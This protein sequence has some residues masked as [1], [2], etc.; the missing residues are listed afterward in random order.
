MRGMLQFIDHG[1]CIVL[2]GNIAVAA[3]INEQ[4]IIPQS[5]LASSCTGLHIRGGRQTRPVKCGF[6]PQLIKSLDGGERTRFDRRRE[7]PCVDDTD[8]GFNLEASRTADTRLMAAD[9][10]AFKM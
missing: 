9:F 6:T 1:D 8:P 2:D 3:R 7:I 5:K 10:T 4:L